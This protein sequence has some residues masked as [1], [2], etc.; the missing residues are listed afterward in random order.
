MRAKKFDKMLRRYKILLEKSPSIPKIYLYQLARKYDDHE[1]L[2][3][4]EIV[5]EIKPI[6]V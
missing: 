4:P 1:S 3:L 6:I 2:V 5:G